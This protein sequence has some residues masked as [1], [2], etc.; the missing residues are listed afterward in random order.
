MKT[1]E[2]AELNILIQILNTCEDIEPNKDGRRI[3]ATEGGYS[4]DCDKIEQRATEIL[5]K[6]L[7]PYKVKE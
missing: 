7:K 5:A 4:L 1:R 6:F 2:I 3:T